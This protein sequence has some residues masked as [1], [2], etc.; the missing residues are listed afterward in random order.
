MAL[1]VKGKIPRTKEFTIPKNVKRKWLRA[2]RSG[3]YDQTTGIL[4]R[5]EV[6]VNNAG[7]VMDP[8]G[9]CCLGVLEHC[10]MDGKVEGGPDRYN[11]GYVSYLVMPSIQYWNLIKARG[12]E[13]DEFDAVMT[14]LS[15]LN[16]DRKVTI[17]DRTSV[18]DDDT[19]AKIEANG[20]DDIAD[21]IAKRV[22]TH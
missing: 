1:K 15:G 9:F 2:L 19:I 14:E 4:Y 13:S 8:A 18:V 12:V 11:N 17:K 16:D 5:D 10:T 20:F 7:K 6:I 3:S 21:Y 22:G